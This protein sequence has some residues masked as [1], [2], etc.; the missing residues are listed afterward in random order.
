MS[1]TASTMLVSGEWFG[2][3][4]PDL[5][6]DPEGQ[7]DPLHVEAPAKMGRNNIAQDITGIMHSTIFASCSGLICPAF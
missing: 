7:G 3:A 2:E 5:P 4:L 6:K 1:V